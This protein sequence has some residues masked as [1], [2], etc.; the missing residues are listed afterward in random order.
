MRSRRGA[1]RRRK[2]R[3]DREPELASDVGDGSRRRPASIA[4]LVGARDDRDEVDDATRR[5]ARE[6]A[7]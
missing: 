1:P 2:V 3:L 5:E 4:W 6:R 7:E